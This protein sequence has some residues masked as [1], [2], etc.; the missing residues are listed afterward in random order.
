M[1]KQIIS[2]RLDQHLIERVDAYAAKRNLTRTDIAD[3]ALRELVKAPSAVPKPAKL[4]RAKPPRKRPAK[5][6]TNG[7]IDRMREDVPVRLK[8]VAAK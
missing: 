6:R 1:P 7:K 3:A 2:L 5:P 4:E 8:G